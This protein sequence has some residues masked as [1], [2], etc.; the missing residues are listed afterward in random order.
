MLMS[1]PF[2]TRNR[3]GDAPDTLVTFG[4][5]EEMPA[6]PITLRVSTVLPVPVL[7]ESVMV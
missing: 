5:E 7:L 3:N 6:V 4:E 2:G 1:S